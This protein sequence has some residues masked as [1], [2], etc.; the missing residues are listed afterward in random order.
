MQA[1]VAVA[2][3]FVLLISIPARSRAQDAQ[4]PDEG[5]AITANEIVV[6][7]VVRDE[8]GRVA[9]GLTAADFDVTEDGVAQEVTSFRFETR[10]GDGGA[11]PVTPS[12]GPSS[13]G[14]RARPTAP[15]AAYGSEDSPAD[16]AAVAL[17]FDRL[18]PE[19][20]LRARDAALRYVNNGLN[21]DDLVGVF[22]TDLSLRV[23]QSF[24]RDE[25]L[26]RKAVDA[27]A[28][29]SQSTAAASTGEQTRS[30][31]DRVGG[32][33]E[34]QSTLQSSITRPVDAAGA[35][36]ASAAG[37]AIGANSAELLAAE[38]TQRSLE[39]FESL[40]RDQQ[41]YATTNGLLAVVNALGR[42]PGRKA[43]IFF[44]EGIAI[45]PNVAPYFR[46]VIG[47][48]NRANVS[49]YAVDAA[50]LRVVSP[51]SETAQELNAAARR[52]MAQVESGSDDLPSLTR[53][54]E[55]NEDM[56]RANPEG[57]LGQLAN[58]TGGFLVSGT[59]DPASRLRLVDEDLRSH[60]VLS[61]MP[62]NQDFDG[63]FRK[64]LVKVRRPGME[65][66]AREGYYAVGS[67]GSLTVL[68]YEARPLA[69]L[70]RRGN[71]KDFP[72]SAVVLT[73]PEPGRPS[74]VPVLVEVPASAL[75]CAADASGKV[76]RTDFTIV[77]V[78]RDAEQQVVRK[79]SS[80]YALG[81]PSD[82]VASFRKGNVLFFRETTLDPGVYSVET[83]AFDAPSGKATVRRRTLAVPADG[84]LRLSSV[85]IVAR[86]DHLKPQDRVAADSLRVGDDLLY[87]ILGVPLSK[88]RDKRV[89]FFVTVYGLSL[90]ALRPGGYELRMT[91]TDRRDTA[92]T[93]SPFTVAP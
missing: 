92:S 74:R 87:P 50:G 24:T 55:R 84:A 72:A 33:Q 67:L 29:Q 52:R 59:N 25:A 89:T 1:L 40:D 63:Q 44:S 39:T 21:P 70:D 26:V 66:R 34:T 77:A 22:V 51:T 18:S 62:K 10:T 60:Y 58:E 61:Y 4:P 28:L 69:A 86:V 38:M 19:A 49:I 13:T 93:S 76:C 47:N 2:V 48:A 30:L 17:V 68:P 3:A 42:V 11:S 32:L 9:K 27:V 64:I 20:R 16:V 90:D 15:G 6:D 91:V 31:G 5:V 23:L 37:A 80:H 73:F 54:L 53:I 75:S 45:P 8:K 36:A 43:V 79:L 7:V 82:R 81:L 56:L 41:G 85:V 46:S 88:S 78:I 35:A 83:I 65:V 71:A 12:P 14:V 57:T